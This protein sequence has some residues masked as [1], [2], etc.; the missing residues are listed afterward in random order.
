MRTL[1]TTEH[2]RRTVSPNRGFTNRKE[3]FHHE[4]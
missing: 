1:P 2:G 4:A 3:F